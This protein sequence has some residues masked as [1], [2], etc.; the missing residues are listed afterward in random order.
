M[1]IGRPVLLG[2]LFLGMGSLT[3]GQASGS[4]AGDQGPP[5]DRPW[6]KVE[7]VQPLVLEPPVADLMDLCAFEDGIVV[8]E[9]AEGR[10]YLY[11][12]DG[13]RR[14]PFPGQG[15]LPPLL[16]GMRLASAGPVVVAVDGRRTLRFLRAEGEVK[17]LKVSDTWS[18]ANHLGL[19]PH[20]L[21]FFGGW[22]SDDPPWTPH[23]RYSRLFSTDWNGKDLR[24]Y[25]SQEFLSME[26]LHDR[27]DT[28]WDLYA[29][30]A[31]WPGVG[32]VVCRTFP[33]QVLL[34]SPEGRLL[35]RSR[36][37]PAQG[38]LPSPASPQETLS[39]IAQTERVVGLIPL[40]PW[41]GVLWQQR[42]KDPVH[43]L[44]IE[45]MGEDL[46]PRGEEA[47][48]FPAALGRQDSIGLKAV[49]TGG[50]AV[51]RI[52]HP[53]GLYSAQWSLYEIQFGLPKKGAS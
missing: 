27:G 31:P 46:E 13:R 29:E 30:F 24:D 6:P 53:L 39:L 22:I 32:Y 19:T 48:S 1:E 10:L 21:F 25:E 44:R 34:F 36:P 7:K 5:R 26:T 50:R 28:L 43:P 9:R 33:R 38:R 3:V 49:T 47:F 15:D 14:G 40:G 20:R 52:S 41:L 18:A 42:A 37:V 11:G 12:P 45:W 51:L 16:D 4:G 8:L 17:R 2:I 23:G 35:R